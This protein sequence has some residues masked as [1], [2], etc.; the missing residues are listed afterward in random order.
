MD[1]VI[2]IA[3]TLDALINENDAHVFED[4]DTVCEYGLGRGNPLSSKRCKMC[5]KLSALIDLSSSW[6]QRI[7]SG[8]LAGRSVE[9]AETGALRTARDAEAAWRIYRECY[10]AQ[11][12][13]QQCLLQRHYKS[14]SCSGRSYTLRDVTSTQT[15]PPLGVMITQL[16]E[17]FTG[18]GLPETFVHGNPTV[19]SISFLGRLP[20]LL[21][22][23]VNLAGVEVKY[24]STY[25]IQIDYGGADSFALLAMRQSR[26]RPPVVEIPAITRDTAGKN[27]V[28]RADSTFATF[29]RQYPDYYKEI[30]LYFL[31]RGLLSLY[32]ASEI[33]EFRDIAP[34][35]GSSARSLKE[36]FELS[37][38]KTIPLNIPALLA[39]RL[40][41]HILQ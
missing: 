7:N 8:S 24:A 14:F 15:P 3:P 17:L 19:A 33:A 34:L 30:A 6:T 2:I 29:L 12:L 25:L 38:G 5:V 13:A 36:A 37:R 21:R 16:I 4:A 18:Q 39:D 28:V 41:S 11:K 31:L 20:V 9:I 10:T 23:T 35:G 40:R 27:L 26:S 22:H 32:P 1:S